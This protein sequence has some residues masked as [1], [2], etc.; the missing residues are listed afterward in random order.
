MTSLA[1]RSIT[2]PISG[3]IWT[4][5]IL[6]MLRARNAPIPPSRALARIVVMMFKR[7]TPKNLAVS[8]SSKFSVIPLSVGC[9]DNA[10]EDLPPGGLQGPFGGHPQPEGKMSEPHFKDRLNRFLASGQGVTRAQVEFTSIRVDPRP[11]NGRRLTISEAGQE[12]CY[13][14]DHVC[15]SHLARLLEDRS[16]A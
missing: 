10:D 14:L 3:P 5:S 13:E 7:I 11:D 8:L 2:E 9:L 15:A 1:S 6:S 16:A 12:R 4:A